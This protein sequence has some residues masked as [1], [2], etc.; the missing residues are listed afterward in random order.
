[1][2]EADCEA[3]NPTE[4]FRYSN[5]SFREPSWRA[6]Y[7]Y[8]FDFDLQLLKRI[9]RADLEE[10]GYQSALTRS[11]NSQYGTGWLYHDS[12]SIASNLCTFT[13]LKAVLSIRSA[14]E[15]FERGLIFAKTVE[16]SRNAT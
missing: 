5:G 11:Q 4:A 10:S 8:D 13:L 12:E 15:P 9:L 7:H 2:A 14:V 1:M 16:S 6:S 3:T